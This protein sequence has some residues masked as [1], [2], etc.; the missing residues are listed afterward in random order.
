MLNLNVL[1]NIF[2]SVRRKSTVATVIVKILSAID[3]LL[4]RKIERLLVVNQMSRF[5]TTSC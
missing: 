2:K 1:L 4:L 3:E 5:K